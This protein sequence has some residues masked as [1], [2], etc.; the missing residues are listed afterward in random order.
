MRSSNRKVRASFFCFAAGNCSLLF[1]IPFRVSGPGSPTAAPKFPR[2]TVLKLS[3]GFRCPNAPGCF[4]YLIFRKNTGI[5]PVFFSCCAVNRGPTQDPHHRP[6]ATK[7][8]SFCC[9]GDNQKEI[10]SSQCR[11]LSKP[12]LYHL[13]YW[14]QNNGFVSFG[15]LPSFR[16]SCES[17]YTL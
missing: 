12:L 1:A 6:N 11:Q 9:V 3:N 7:P 17:N 10:V 14:Q 2:F 13:W 8:M 4:C 15:L 5:T 16:G